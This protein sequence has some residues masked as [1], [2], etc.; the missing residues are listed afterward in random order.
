[1]IEGRSHT[2]D[3]YIDTDVIIPR[4]Y[5]TTPAEPGRHSLE[6]LDP[7]IADGVGIV[8]YVREHLSEQGP[9]SR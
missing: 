1:V 6:G 4:R 2:D 5:G 9:A 3:D 7:G 8:P